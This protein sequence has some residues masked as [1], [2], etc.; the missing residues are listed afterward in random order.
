[1]QKKANDLFFY[2]TLKAREVR[3]AVLGYEVNDD[4][5]LGAIL[6]GFQVRRVVGAH[7]PMLVASSPEDKVSGIIMQDIDKE[8]LEKLD[9][10]EGKDYQRIW[11][12]AICDGQPCSVQIYKPNARLK[13]AEIWD[14]QDWYQND[15]EKFL[16]QDFN[17]RGVRRPE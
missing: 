7:Y 4:R 15:L 3:K 12:E 11:V 1:M 5:L 10:F 9:R 17:L 14:F 8:D 13:G 16:E 6:S 2:G